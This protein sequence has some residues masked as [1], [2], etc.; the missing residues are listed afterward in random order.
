LKAVKKIWQTLFVRESGVKRYFLNTGWLVAARGTQM[1][2]SLFIGGW[3]ARYLGPDQY[4][5]YNYIISFV[6]IFAALSTMG[7]APV[8]VKDMVA[9]KTDAPTAMGSG[10]VL[11]LLGSLLAWILV[12]AFSFIVKDAVSV[13][14]LL[15]IA[16]VQTV[17]RST[18]IMQ[19][20]YQA[21]VHSSTTVKAQ[22]VSLVVVNATR[23][24]FILTGKPLEWFIWILPADAMIIGWLMM[25]FMRRSEAPVRSWT[26]S[27][28]YARTILSESWPSLFSGIFVTIYMKIDQV[29]IQS[30]LGEEQVGYYAAAVRMSEVWISIPWILSGSLFPA[31]V[32]AFKEGKEAFATRINQAY[33][34]LISIALLVAVP[35]ALFAPFIIRLIFGDS[36][37]TS[38]AILQLHIFSCVFIFLGSVSNR[39]LVIHSLQRYWMYYSA[40]GAVMNIMLNIWMLPQYGIMGAALATLL[41]YGFAY[42]LVFALFPATRPLFRVQTANFARVLLIIPAIREVRKI[43][44]R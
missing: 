2:V 17:I 28:S 34:L 27:A 11:K 13:R 24:G 38:A 18:E 6:A 43:K 26:F 4:G 19:A 3:V 9:G 33:I 41:S 44:I 29:M 14:L 8:V 10:F 36:Y 23:V 25:R 1:I 15:A 30:I 5:T 37:S 21:K 16:A 40:A 7:I 32:N 20:Y 31:M 22:M 35:V 42:Y 39:W 12:I